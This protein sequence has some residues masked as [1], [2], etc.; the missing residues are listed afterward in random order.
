MSLA[1]R[2]DLPFIIKSRLEGSKGRAPGDPLIVRLLGGA[3]CRGA[4][5]T[6]PR[7]KPVHVLRGHGCSGCALRSPTSWGRAPPVGV[8]VETG[9]SRVRALGGGAVGTPV[10]LTT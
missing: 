10:L 8:G 5:R 3:L 2:M 9:R 4:L 7:S 6:R 1:G